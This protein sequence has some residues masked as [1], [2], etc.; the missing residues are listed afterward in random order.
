MSKTWDVQELRERLEGA[1]K[2]LDVDDSTRGKIRAVVVQNVCDGRVGNHLDKTKRSSP[3]SYVCLVATHYSQYAVFM[4]MLKA[5]DCDAIRA[6]QPALEVAVRTT[7]L[8]WGVWFSSDDLREKTHDI[9]TDVTMELI[10]KN[11]HYECPP[12]A[13]TYGIVYNLCCHL[14]RNATKQSTPQTVGI[15]TAVA[16]EYLT[17]LS[18]HL[19]TPEQEVTQDLDLQQAI[20]QLSDKRQTFILLYYIMG[21]DYKSIAEILGDKPNSLY[22]LKS[23]ALE[24]LG[25]I[26]R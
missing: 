5:G 23:D 18:Q 2:S 7:L 15:D 13:W 17:L 11:F 4:R 22:K 25:K 16:E 9:V 21:Y 10:E 3:E 14:V 8:R 20:A 6:L 1:I 26:Y 24:Q 12:L 19:P